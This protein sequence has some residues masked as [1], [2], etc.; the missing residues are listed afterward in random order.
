MRSLLSYWRH[1]EIHLLLAKPT[2]GKEPHERRWKPVVMAADVRTAEEY[3]RRSKLE[4]PYW[5]MA[6]AVLSPISG[7]QVVATHQTDEF[8]ESE[9]KG[10]L[11]TIIESDFTVAVAG[12]WAAVVRHPQE[13]C[14]F[15]L[16]NV[17]E[18]DLN[19]EGKVN[20]E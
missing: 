8:E 2:E 1:C 3:A 11:S 15:G 5:P 16:L 18:S 7:V 4:N 6:L 12:A 9:L 19:D 20:R 14:D 10:V 13:I 17:E